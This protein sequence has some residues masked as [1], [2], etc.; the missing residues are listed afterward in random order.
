MDGIADTSL[1]L[2]RVTSGWGGP[3]QF[4]EVLIA[5]PDPEAARVF[6]EGAFGG[7]TQPVCRARMRLFDLGPVAAG[8]VAGPRRGGEDYPEP[9]LTTDVRC[10][11]PAVG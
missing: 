8:V 4:E 5:A 10:D 1:H 2:W 11:D 3:F 7:V 9:A 6:A